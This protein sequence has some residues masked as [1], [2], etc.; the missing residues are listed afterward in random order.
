MS[1]EIDRLLRDAELRS[2]FAGA[3]EE[4]SRLVKRVDEYVTAEE[5]KV[6]SGLPF[7]EEEIYAADIFTDELS[8]IQEQLKQIQQVLKGQQKLKGGLG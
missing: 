8:R 7:N 1:D 5:R 6:D 3:V 4:L 2:K